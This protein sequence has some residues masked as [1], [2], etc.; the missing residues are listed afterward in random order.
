MKQVEQV[1]FAGQYAAQR[2]QPVL[3]VTERCVFLLAEHG[4]ELIEV[5][6]GIEIE[7]DILAHMDFKPHIHKPVPM[8]PAIF[9]DEPME[10]LADLLNVKLRERVTYDAERNMLIVNLDGWSVRKK[11]DVADLQKVLVDA[12]T[13]AGRRVDAIINQDGCRIAEDLYDAYADMVAYVAKHHYARTARYAT[14]IFTRQK[15]QQALRARRGLRTSSRAP[16]RR[17]P[18]WRRSTHDPEG[19]RPCR[20]APRPGRGPAKWPRR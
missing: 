2:S 15:M 7:R 17:T 1:T 11:N 3:Y 8:N 16:R 18:P 13:A 10:L 5:A 14:S 6:P 12:C 19:K 20:M 4:L 9:R